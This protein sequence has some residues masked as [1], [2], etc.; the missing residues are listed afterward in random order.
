MTGA[1]SGSSG[2][3]V[4]GSQKNQEASPREGLENE[5]KERHPELCTL[6]ALACHNLCESPLCSLRAEVSESYQE[7]GC[8]ITRKRSPPIAGGA[9]N[10][11]LG[12]TVAHPPGLSPASESHRQLV[13][14]LL[15]G[16]LIP[17][18]EP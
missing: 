17:T 18:Q 4:T 15:L 7:V 2:E 5:G 8:T 14:F 12:V 9:V 3:W 16:A 10:N 13:I 6:L 1:Y 11:E